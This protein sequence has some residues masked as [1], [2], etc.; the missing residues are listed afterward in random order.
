MVDPTDKDKTHQGPKHGYRGIP[1]KAESESVDIIQADVG[2][3]EVSGN[4]ESLPD[5][6]TL[7]PNPFPT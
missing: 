6:S 7:W 1:C 5:L 3:F 2:S 4:P